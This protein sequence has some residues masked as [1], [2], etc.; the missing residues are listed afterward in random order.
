MASS[1]LPAN[2][3]ARSNLAVAYAAAGEYERAVELV[4]TALGLAPLEPLATL[5][6]DHLE[7]YKER[8]T[9]R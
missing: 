5:L 7:L 2:V 1:N 6:R 3:E 4:Q 9:K 8:R